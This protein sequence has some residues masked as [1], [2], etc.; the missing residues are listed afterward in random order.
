M[1]LDDRWTYPASGG[2]LVNRLG[3]RDPGFLGPA[4]NDYA[5]VAW[6]HLRQLPPPEPPGF[7]YLQTIDR[8]M[9][10]SLLD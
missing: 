5:S 8:E 9:F 3:I 2:V 7:D 1:T 10:G 6:V 4:L